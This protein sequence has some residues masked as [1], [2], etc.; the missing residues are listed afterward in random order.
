KLSPI[1]VGRLETS[2]LFMAEY[3]GTLK[4]HGYWPTNIVEPSE[5]V[6]EVVNLAKNWKIQLGQG[7]ELRT[8]VQHGD[9][10]PNNIIMRRRSNPV[11]IDLSRL[12]H[13]PVGYDL[14]RLSLMLR[15]RLVDVDRHEDWL[16]DKLDRWQSEPIAYLDQ[17][18]DPKKSLCPESAFCDQQFYHF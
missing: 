4:E 7:R 1:D 2:A 6:G 10:N 12:K 15:L 16:P 17:P 13:W 3:G 11:L 5:V 14:A 18:Q 9:L 8:V